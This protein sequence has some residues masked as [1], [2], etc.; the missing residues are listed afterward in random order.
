MDY[1]VATLAARNDGLGLLKIIPN[2]GFLQPFS[3]N[4][5]IVEIIRSSVGWVI[6]GF[7]YATR[8]L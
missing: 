5:A 1:R 4:H 7:I 8:P 6:T 2:L 3:I